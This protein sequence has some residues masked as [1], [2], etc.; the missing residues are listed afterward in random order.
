MELNWQW[1][2]IC[3]TLMWK[4]APDGVVITRKDLGALPQDRVLVDYRDPAGT[5][6][7]FSF[8]SLDEARRLRPKI[9]KATGHKA[10]VSELQGRWQKITCVLLWKLARDGCVLTQLDRDA[11]PA[12]QVLLAHG[13]AQDIEYRFCPRA[14]AARIQKAELEHEGKQI[15]EVVR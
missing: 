9:L 2:E 5:L 15:L 12:D 6:I 8:V 4:L 7:R 14:E 13:H 10:G 11:V 1:P 3:V